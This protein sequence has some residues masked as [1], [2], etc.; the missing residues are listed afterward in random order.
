MD[1]ETEQNEN[2]QAGDPGQSSR[3]SSTYPF[4]LDAVVLAGT[5]QNTKRLIV[6]V[7]I[8]HFWMWVEKR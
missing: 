1:P 3:C 6:Q 8:R 2:T 5:H 4:P 7:V